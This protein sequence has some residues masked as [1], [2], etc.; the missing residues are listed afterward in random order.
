MNILLDLRPLTDKYYSGV[1]EFNLQLV[2][3]LLILDQANNYQGLYTSFHDLSHHLP[4]FSQP[5]KI[6]RLPW[7]N[8]VLNGLW[9]VFNRPFLDKLLPLYDRQSP[10]SFDLL[11]LPHFNFSASSKSLPKVITVHDVSFLRFSEFFNFKKNLWHKFLRVKKILM[12]CQK[13]VAVSEQT[14]L[15]LLELCGLPPEKVVTV[16]SGVD[17]TYHPMDKEDKKIV[18]VRER[19]GLK[20]PFILSLGTLEPRKNLLCLIAAFEQIKKRGVFS[21]GQLVLAGGRGWKWRPIIKAAQASPYHKDIVFLDYVDR[22]DKPALYNA[23]QLFVYPSFYEGFGFPPLEAMACG[24]PT[25]AS[26]VSSLPEIL[27]QAAI[28]IN[29]DNSSE[30]AE[31]ISLVLTD[32]DLK[33]DLSQKGIKQAALFTWQKT[34]EAYLEIFKEVVEDNK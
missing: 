30:L 18:A 34:A 8:K 27:G 32:D 21:N 13:V 16:Y 4:S 20:A 28:L 9:W 25:I 31:A 15:D 7:P 2:R 3:H 10:V 33:N 23:A 6:T 11:Y 14:R 17:E 24:L 19:Y 22:A 1:A 12:S 5:L 29:P 26:A